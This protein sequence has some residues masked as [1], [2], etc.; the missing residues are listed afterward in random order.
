MIP[1]GNHND[2]IWPFS[3]IPRTANAVASDT[4]PKLVSSSGLLPGYNPDVPN[5]GAWALSTC[6]YG[7]CYA[8]TSLSGITVRAGTFRY[9][10]VDKYYTFPTFTVKQLGP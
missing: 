8:S 6:Q 3:L 2:W 9:D 4:P 7:F 10:Y 5:P 1:P